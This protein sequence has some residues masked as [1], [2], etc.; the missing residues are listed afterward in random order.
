MEQV[1]RI[2]PP[3]GGM[4]AMPSFSDLAEAEK[5]GLTIPPANPGGGQQGRVPPAIRKISAQYEAVD[6]LTAAAR[7]AERQK[8][9]LP[10]IAGGLDGPGEVDERKVR[11]NTGL[12]DQ[13]PTDAPDAAPGPG[14]PQ[15]DKRAAPTGDT[16]MAGMLR[17]FMAAPTTQQPT[18]DPFNPPPLVDRT[19]PLSS[20]VPPREPAPAVPP[21]VAYLAKR[22]RVG[23]T[24]AGGTYSVP[25]VD[26]QRCATGLVILLPVDPQSA[27]FVPSLGAEVGIEYE[28]KR[29]DCFFPGVAVVLDQLGVQILS[30]VF[31][32]DKQA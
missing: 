11:G 9:R 20:N 22:G 1:T 30:F 24:V 31:K 14:A 27:T 19:V 8:G 4:R 21:A 28:G 15:V 17:A 16:D 7:M 32:D 23:F 3:P 10:P 18:L 12:V 2:I 13:H 25:A 5:A 26:V 6:M 29:W